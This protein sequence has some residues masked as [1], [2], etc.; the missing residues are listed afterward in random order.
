MRSTGNTTVKRPIAALIGLGLIT[1]LPGLV[2][3]EPVPLGSDVQIAG[4]IVK[5]SYALLGGQSASFIALQPTSTVNLVGN[6][7]MNSDVVARIPNYSNEIA[8]IDQ[9]GVP[10]GLH[11]DT[12]IGKAVTISGKVWNMDNLRQAPHPQMDVKDVQ[13]VDTSKL[14]TKKIGWAIE[15]P[16]GLGWAVAPTLSP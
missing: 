14:Q 11:L 4:K 13:I 2:H 16:A 9:S 12:L 6:D 5:D 3:A 10:N 8:L 7:P 1:A 15:A